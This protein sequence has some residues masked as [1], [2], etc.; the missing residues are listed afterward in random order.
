MSCTSMSGLM[1]LVLYSIQL[2]VH[3]VVVTRPISIIE[4]LLR[5]KVS[6]KAARLA[7][8]CRTLSY[9]ATE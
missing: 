3:R 6:F 9:L 5:Q 2:G 8:N 1:C 4:T 7:Q